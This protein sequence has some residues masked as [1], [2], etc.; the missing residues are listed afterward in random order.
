MLGNAIPGSGPHVRNVEILF[1][2]IVVVQPANAHAR[3]NIFDARLRSDIGEGAI[4]VVAVEI[5]AAEIIH[6]I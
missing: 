1:A 3:A 2:V 5:F 4:A 6:H